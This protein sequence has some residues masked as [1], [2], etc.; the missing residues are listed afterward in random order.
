MLDALIAGRLPLWLGL[1]LL[2]WLGFSF[3]SF[4]LYGWD[5]WAA[6]RGWR[7]IPEWRLHLL[8]WLG[9]WPGAWCAQYCFRHKTVKPAFRRMFWLSVLGNLSLIVMISLFVHQ[10]GV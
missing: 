6:K 2:P 1:L 9:G 3:L 7:R 10:F 4:L 5:K 8:A